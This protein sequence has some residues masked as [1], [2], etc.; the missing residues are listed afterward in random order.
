MNRAMRKPTMWFPNRFNTS[1]AVQAL[2]MARGWIYK[3]D[4]LF[5]PCSEN[6]STFIFAYGKC[7]FSHDTT[8]IC[9]RLLLLMQSLSVYTD[10][11]LR[12]AS[13]EGDSPGTP[14]TS[15]SVGVVIK[16]YWNRL[17]N[18]NSV[19]KQTVAEVRLQKNGKL[20]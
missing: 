2:K 12:V 15:T 18:L 14:S 19:I 13:S 6:N 4:V 9:F 8:Q 1:R 10:Q 5:Y 16:K 17:T 7:W 20:F 11:A 3:I